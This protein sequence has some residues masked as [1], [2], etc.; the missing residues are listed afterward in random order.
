MKKDNNGKSFL[1]ER[2][3]AWGMT[4]L[5]SVLLT[6]TILFTAVVHLVTSGEF[7]RRLAEDGGLIERQ[8]RYVYGCVDTMA[9]EYG[10]SA[11]VVKQ[12]VTREKLKDFNRETAAWWTRF[13]NGEQA[14]TVPRWRSDT[15]E[16]AVYA[17]VEDGSLR[18][19]PKRILSEVTQVIERTVFPMRETLMAAGINIA[20]TNADL[21]GIIHSVRKLPLLG[22][23]LCLAA[24]GM[25][26]LLL[27]RE[28]VRNL[29]H[30]GTAAAGTGFSLISI[31]V[32]I[33]LQRPGIPLKEASAGLDMV[34][35][36][37]LGKIGFGGGAAAAAMIA[38]GYIC[39]VL[40]RKKTGT[41]SSAG[42]RKK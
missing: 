16:E 26:V 1:P 29:K 27:G 14:G 13:L 5:F 31:A 19:D 10:F 24:A 37:M 3:A 32:I 17:S 2:G 18:S 9:A 21:P 35:G 15:M 4:M 40:F 6:V 41:Q 7:H 39:L 23:V 25:I 28:P 8:L 38:A 33:L 34:I 22:L 30:F 36:A 42:E 20:H 11:D 12:E